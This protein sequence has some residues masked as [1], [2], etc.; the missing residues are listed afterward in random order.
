MKSYY[1]YKSDILKKSSIKILKSYVISKVPLE[2]VDILSGYLRMEGF[3]VPYNN[4]EAQGM[5]VVLK[6]TRIK[7]LSKIKKSGLFYEDWS[8]SRI[9]L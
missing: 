9:K 5:V 6:T 8:I 2:D 4:L 3:D 1:N 7:L